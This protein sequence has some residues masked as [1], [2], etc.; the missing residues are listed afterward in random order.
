ME[1]ASCLEKFTRASI[2]DGFFLLR[3]IVRKDKSRVVVGG[4]CGVKVTAWKFDICSNWFNWTRLRLIYL[5]FLFLMLELWSWNSNFGTIWLVEMEVWLEARGVLEKLNIFRFTAR[6][7]S[8]V[9]FSQGDRETWLT[10]LSPQPRRFLMI[11]LYCLTRD[12]Q[13]VSCRNPISLTHCTMSHLMKQ[14]N[15]N[16]QGSLGRDDHTLRK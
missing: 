15:W 8:P 16:V 6:A 12:E 13:Y 5:I 1:L 14:E 3:H 10:T 7:E 2:F 9:I 4:W 11:S